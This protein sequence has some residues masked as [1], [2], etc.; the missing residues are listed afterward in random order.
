MI[1]THYKPVNPGSEECFNFKEM[2]VHQLTTHNRRKHLIYFPRNF[3][4]FTICR[5]WF[6]L[7]SRA[8]ILICLSRERLL[9]SPNSK[10]TPCHSNVSLRHAWCTQYYETKNLNN[11]R[12]EPAELSSHNRVLNLNYCWR[13]NWKLSQRRLED[14]FNAHKIFYNNYGIVLY[15]KCGLNRKIDEHVSRMRTEWPPWT[16]FSAIHNGALLI[17]WMSN[18]MKTKSNKEC[19]C[20]MTHKRIDPFILISGLENVYFY[21]VKNTLKF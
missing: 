12:Q 18:F 3:C 14:E 1:T 7:T 21:W 9:I 8:A 5:L 4:C 16:I 15:M 2:K 10:V 20:V 19:A 6:I 11:R 17:V 13:G